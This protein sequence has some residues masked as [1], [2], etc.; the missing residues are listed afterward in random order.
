MYLEAHLVTRMVLLQIDDVGLVVV[1]LH[2]TLQEALELLGGSPHG[3]LHHKHHITGLDVLAPL[4][5]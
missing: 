4:S 5:E 1:A 3:N 2:L